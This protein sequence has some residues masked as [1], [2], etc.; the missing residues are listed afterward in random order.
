MS[1]VVD[2]FPFRGR[3]RGAQF[4]WETWFDGRVHRC[5]RGVDFMS[6]PKTFYNTAYVRA[7]RTGVVVRMSIVDDSVFIQAKADTVAACRAC[8]RALLSENIRVADGCPC[9]SPR[10]VNHGLVPKNTCTC[11][12]CDPAQT[13][14]TRYQV[15][16]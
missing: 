8:N 11:N 7:M 16:P 1:E 2:E 15:Q 14:S 4:P 13:G 12:E 3:N 5:D 6:T 9:N 10:G